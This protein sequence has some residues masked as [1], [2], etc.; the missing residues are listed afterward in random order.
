MFYGIQMW[1]RDEGWDLFCS[2]GC[3]EK[4]HPGEQPVYFPTIQDYYEALDPHGLGLQGPHMSRKMCFACCG[5]LNLKD[6][7]AA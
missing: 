2:P 1:P 4:I 3:V 7:P 5:V 6:R